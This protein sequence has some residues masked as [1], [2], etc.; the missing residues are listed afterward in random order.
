MIGLGWLAGGFDIKWNG[1]FGLFLSLRFLIS[2]LSLPLVFFL[3]SLFSLY[4][5]PLF[6]CLLGNHYGGMDRITGLTDSSMGWMDGWVG[7][8]ERKGRKR[9]YKNNIHC[10]CLVCDLCCAVM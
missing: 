10:Y 2:S 8:R 7:R 9:N 5:L 4:L 1:W 3:F 6:F